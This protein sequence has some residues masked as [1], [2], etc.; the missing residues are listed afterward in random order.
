[1]SSNITAEDAIIVLVDITDQ[2]IPFTSRQTAVGQ[3]ILFLTLVGVV[4]ELLIIIA[5]LRQNISGNIDTQLILS[6]VFSDLIFS[7]LFLVQNGIHLGS[8]GW[9]VILANYI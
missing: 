5:C 6:L 4:M 8:G 3:I 7:A 1:M 9:W 2:L